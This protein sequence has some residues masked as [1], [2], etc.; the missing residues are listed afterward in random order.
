MRR[1]ARSQM[2][3]RRAEGQ[4]DANAWG[5]PRAGTLVADWS[6]FE[7]SR[8]SDRL[9]RMPRPSSSKGRVVSVRFESRVLEGNPLGDPHVRTI[10]VY[11]PPGYD[12]PA[13]AKRRYPTAYVL[14]G[15]TGK[16]TMLLNDSGWT[17]PLDRRL[18]RLIG[19]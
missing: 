12:E 11:L 14:T 4:P 5:A 19:S 9:P 6:A 17:D 1:R 13:Q 7:A 10:P 16:G 3:S 8:S 18:D 2:W 15:F